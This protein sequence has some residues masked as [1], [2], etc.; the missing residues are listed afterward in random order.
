VRLLR[1]LRPR[2]VLSVGGY[3]GGPVGLAAFGLGIP[4]GILEPNSIVGF[5]NRV[6][7]PLSSRAYVAWPTA[8]PSFRPSSVRLYGVP[9]R[10]GFAAKPYAPRGT[11][12]VLV[13]GGSQGAQAL[14][15]RVPDA[16]ALVARQVRNLDVVHQTGR[17]QEAVVSAAYVREGVSARVVPFLDNVAGELSWADL[18]IARAGAVTLAEIAAVG[19]ASILIP[20]PHAAEDHQAKNAEVLASKGAA[21]AIRQESADRA[22]IAVEATRVLSEAATR[23]IMA[24]AARGLGTPHAAFDVALDLLSLAGISPRHRDARTN[25]S[26]P[27]ARRREAN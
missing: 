16:L 26:G 8:V 2:A 19:R 4:L 23:T 14:N 10:G 22:R 13:M 12:R 1:R 7:S 9:L 15:E 18:V 20:F 5:T 27:E 6:L 17:D 24:A 11:A 25:G 21:I 3:A